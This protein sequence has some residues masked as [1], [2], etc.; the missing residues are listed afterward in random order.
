MSFDFRKM[1]RFIPIRYRLVALFF[2][3]SI[4]PLGVIAAV[5]ADTVYVLQRMSF[6]SGLRIVKNLAEE[7]FRELARSEATRVSQHFELMLADLRRVQD[8]IEDVLSGSTRRESGL[9]PVELVRRSS[10][11]WASPNPDDLRPVY[12]YPAWGQTLPDGV[13]NEIPRLVSAEGFLSQWVR[14]NPSA[15][16]A[17]IVTTSSLLLRYPP[18]DPDASGRIA[19][20]DPAFDFRQLESYRRV[21]PGENPDRHIRLIGT[22]LDPLG[23]AWVLTF[24][25]PLW[26]RSGEFLGMLAVNIPLERITPLLVEP[27]DRGGF[28]RV[29]DQN[30]RLVGASHSVHAAGLPKSGARSAG[31]ELV[32]LPVDEAGGL[33]RERARLAAGIGS[34]EVDIGDGPQLVAFHKIES[35]GW[36]LYLGAPAR[37]FSE[38]AMAAI[39]PI[40]QQGVRVWLFAGFVVVLIAVLIVATAWRV[41]QSITQPLETLTEAVE[42]MGAGSQAVAVEV[43]RGDELGKLAR[44]FNRMAM[45]LADS[46]S[47]AIEAERMAFVGQMSAVLAHEIR[48]PLNSLVTTT[49][50]LDPENATELSEEEKKA[51][52]GVLRKETNRLNHILTDFLAYARPREIKLSHVNVRAFLEGI[53]AVL[54]QNEAA[55]GKTIE[56]SVKD[57][58]ETVPF[59]EDQMEQVLINIGIN[60]LQA[61]SEGG[62]IRLEARGEVAPAGAASGR[63]KGLVTVF[64][65]S[66]TGKGLPPEMK[67]RVFEPFFTTK[68]KGT[69]L[70]LAIARRFIEAHGGAIEVDSAPGKG[71]R[72]TILLPR[73]GD[74]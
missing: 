23:G 49:H 57:L 26:V 36:T 5:V 8:Q 56:V 24:A 15:S 74:T 31:H 29:Y 28:V 65:V 11:I 40:F 72:F 22:H 37:V 12:L 67:D 16:A 62:V 6:E 17:Y 70:G 63:L 7:N 55:A 42:S 19:G 3:I 60:G 4:L 69:G 53:A 9:R 20:L 61:M 34:F 44:A 58:P 54:K 13:R 73:Q 59:D 30:E 45:N 32:M 52:F 35:M 50:L 41:S 51:L 25:A 1:N 2:S 47:K 66:D 43:D 33:M 21:L 27:G 46:R 38:G 64:E 14:S 48:N 39:K 18:S 68:K 10:G 71:T